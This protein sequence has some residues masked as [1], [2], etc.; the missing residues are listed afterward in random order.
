MFEKITFSAKPAEDIKVGMDLKL[1][2]NLKFD[3]AISGSCD[4]KSLAKIVR[5]IKSSAKEK[6]G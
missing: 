2:D 1:P 4:K 6:N 3:F 5:I